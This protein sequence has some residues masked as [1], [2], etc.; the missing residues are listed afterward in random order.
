MMR[1]RR[2]RV[3]MS[4]WMMTVF[5]QRCSRKRWLRDRGSWGIRLLFT[6]RRRGIR[7]SLLGRMGLLERLGSLLG[8]YLVEV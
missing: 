1:T 6:M 7:R 2:F 4:F 3:R 5:C 8:R